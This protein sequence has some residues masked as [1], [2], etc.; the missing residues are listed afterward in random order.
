MGKTVDS[1][2]YEIETNN[3]ECLLAQALRDEIAKKWEESLRIARSKF[4]DKRLNVYWEEEI[5]QLADFQLQVISQYQQRC[6][7]SRGMYLSWL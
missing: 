1:M 3:W 7:D 6:G 5:D 4:I 2:R